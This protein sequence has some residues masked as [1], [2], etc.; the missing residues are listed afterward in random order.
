MLRG[1]KGEGIAH[2]GCL[3]VSI[4][5]PQHRQAWPTANSHIIFP[6]RWADRLLWNPCA[7]PHNRAGF[8]L[9]LWSPPRLCIVR[10]EQPDRR[11]HK[12]ASLF[13]DKTERLPTPSPARARYGSSAVVQSSLLYATHEA[14]LQGCASDMLDEVEK[15][16][17]QIAIPNF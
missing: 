5:A 6:H 2:G 15:L 4:P 14:P 16:P 9:G 12:D 10:L 8:P 1:A 13:R 17:K 7:D 3:L 11:H